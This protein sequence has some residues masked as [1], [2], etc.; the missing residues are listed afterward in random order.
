MYSAILNNSAVSI[1]AAPS[2]SYDATVFFDRIKNLKGMFDLKKTKRPLAILLAALMLTL[3]LPLAALAEDCL[4]TN[5]EWR[6]TITPG[7]TVAGQEAFYC[8]DC[9]EYS[10]H[11]SLPRVHP[12]G[13]EWIVTTIPSC[14]AVGQ[15][16]YFCVDCHEGL[17]YNILPKHPNGG[18][19]IVTDIPDCTKTGQEGYFCVDCQEGLA[20]NILP[21]KAHAFSDWVITDEGFIGWFSPSE[22]GRRERRCT[23]C[24]YLQVDSFSP[25][26]DPNPLT[27]FLA[28]FIRA[29]ITVFIEWPSAI[30]GFLF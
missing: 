4:H 24:G 12:N 6:T 16:G 8:W 18:A 9:G 29:L 13:G 19:W 30:F 21:K 3:V 14:T 1:R 10:A 17:A 26:R 5:G 22:D 15:E 11:H 28:G 20:Y 25:S 27:D 2:L 7:C 23:D